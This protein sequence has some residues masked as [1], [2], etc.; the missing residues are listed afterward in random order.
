MHEQEKM[1]ADMSSVESPKTQSS[2]KEVRAADHRTSQDVPQKKKTEQKEAAEGVLNR[3]APLK[4]HK[5]ASDL[6]YIDTSTETTSY[7]QQDLTPSAAPH[8]HTAMNT[9]GFMLDVGI[10]I[11]PA[12]IFSVYRFGFRA[13]TVILL[14]VLPCVLFELWY[15]LILGI[16][17]A[18]TDGS[19]LVTGMLLACIF[20]ATVPL[21][22]PPVAALIAIIGVKQAF[23]GIGRNYVNPAL[24][25]KAVLFCFAAQSLTALPA[26]GHRYAAIETVM[27][28]VQTASPIAQMK[29][30][31]YPDIS[32]LQQFFG[33]GR[34]MLGEV[35][36]ALLLLGGIYLILR[37]IVDWRVPVSFLGTL[38]LLSL[39][40]SPYSLHGTYALYQLCSGGVMLGAFFLANDPVTSPLTDLG[41]LLYGAG[42]GLI[43]FLFCYLEWEAVSVMIAILVMNLAARGLDRIAAPRPFGAPQKKEMRTDIC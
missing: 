10:A 17:L 28:A 18:V 19:A 39:I 31:Q 23:G 26:D 38:A 11:L 29:A 42:C 25:G 1:N 37:R 33:F 4:R 14:S 43:T 16:P 22:M 34:G 30:G 41:R 12:L 5:K 21:W 8:L 36:G 6:F 24:A 3:T 27:D 9:R 32:L 2:P 35:S 20:P 15:Q 13:L 7:I 40:F